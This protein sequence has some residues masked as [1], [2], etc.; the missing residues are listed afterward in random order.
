M[1]SQKGVYDSCK[2]KVRTIQEAYDAL[3]AAAEDYQ[4]LLKA[5]IEGCNTNDATDQ[6][7]LVVAQ[8]QRNT[9]KGIIG[10]LD[11]DL[12]DDLIRLSDRVIRFK[13]WEDGV[14]V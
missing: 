8:L 4:S 2:A 11:T 10:T 14:F 7:L 9:T 12:H 3:V 1:A 5:L 6:H 13:H